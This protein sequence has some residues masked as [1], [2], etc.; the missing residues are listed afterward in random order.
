LELVVFIASFKYFF[1][2]GGEQFIV[3]LQT[4]KKIGRKP[5]AKITMFGFG[6]AVALYFAFY[7]TRT[8]IPTNLLEILLGAGLLYFS[9]DMF[10]EA[11]EGEQKDGEKYRFG[12]ISIVLLEAVENSAALAALTFV[13]MTSAIVG[14]MV[15]VAILV[16]LALKSS[17]FDRISISKLRLISGTLLAIT[18]VPLILYGIGLSTPDWL[19]WI[20]PPLGHT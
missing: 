15:A 17:I 13:D 3:G 19:H 9:F 5:T 2:E 20:I 7:F 8:L 1:V 4:S 18:A 16:S 11:F 14:V 6:L 12:Y 10:K